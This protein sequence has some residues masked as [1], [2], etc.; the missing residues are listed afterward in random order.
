MGVSFR[1]GRH[2]L[3]FRKEKDDEGKV[4]ALQDNVHDVAVEGHVIDANW[5]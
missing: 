2:S 3:R 5:S 4:D 1:G